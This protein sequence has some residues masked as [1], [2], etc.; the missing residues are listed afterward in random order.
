MFISSFFRDISYLSIPLAKESPFLEPLKKAFNQ[1]N[2]VGIIDN[3]WERHQTLVDKMC[4]ERK[5]FNLSFLIQKEHSQIKI[6][7]SI[8]R[9]L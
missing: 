1:M 4:E 8:Y 9:I 2:L 3:I 5:V 7:Y 6:H